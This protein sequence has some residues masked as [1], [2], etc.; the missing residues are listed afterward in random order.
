M[1][2]LPHG[3]FAPTWAHCSNIYVFGR[4]LSAHGCYSSNGAL[5]RSSCS[6]SLPLALMLLT[7]GEELDGPVA[8]TVNT[9]HCPSGLG[10]L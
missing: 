2:L 5:E 7:Q 1:V 6:P 3:G 4:S 9:Y 10:E 8:L